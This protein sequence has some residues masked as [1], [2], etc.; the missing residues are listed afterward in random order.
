MG[1]A[2][3]DLF[4]RL[5][6]GSVGLP[7]VLGLVHV[8]AVQREVIR[9][10]TIAIDVG[11]VVS[12]RAVVRVVAANDGRARGATGING[13]GKIQ[14]DGRKI[15]AVHRQVA[16][17]VGGKGAVQDGVVGVQ[18]GRGSVD[19]DARRGT[20]HSEG[21]VEVGGL[22]NF[23][24]KGRNG[25]GLEPAGLHLHLI[26]ADGKKF[27]AIETHCI[28]R[29]GSVHIGVEVVG[30]HF[31][32]GNDRARGVLHFTGNCAGDVLAKCN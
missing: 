1:S 6:R 14:G 21:H 32:A 8:D 10:G 26:M 24:V 9:L 19:T 7:V 22:Q 17:G 16:D 5:G 12:A 30:H 25:R 11:R 18:D 2:H 29:C 20:A 28:G 23:Q 3:L 13:T 27:D 31:S 4:Q 15:Q